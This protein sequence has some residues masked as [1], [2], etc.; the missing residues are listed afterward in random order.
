MALDAQSARRR[1]HRTPDHSRVAQLLPAPDLG[2]PGL[3]DG[4][5]ELVVGGTPYLVI[6][7]TDV[8]EITVLAVRHGRRKRD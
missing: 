7:M 3:V 2:R 4:T 8:A 6:Y 5:R 1:T